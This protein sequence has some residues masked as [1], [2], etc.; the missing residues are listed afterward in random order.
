MAGFKSSEISE[1]IEQIRKMYATYASQYKGNNTFDVE[2][3]NGRY[4][5][6]LQ[7]K[8]DIS[9]FVKAELSVMEDLVKRAEVWY[10]EKMKNQQVNEETFM[11]KVDAM[12]EKFSDAITKY[13]AVSIHDNSVDEIDR[14]YGAFIELNACYRSIRSVLIE[15]KDYSVETMLKDI[16]TKIQG[17]AISNI[18][19]NPPAIYIDYYR[20]LNQKQEASRSEQFVLKEAG[21]FLHGFVY[22]FDQIAP[23]ISRIPIEVSVLIPEDIRQTA[24][25]VYKSL[26]NKNQTEVFLATKSYAGAMINDFRLQHFRQSN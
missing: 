14:L 18:A 7:E 9:T 15:L 3:F 22:K 13:P 19:G 24:P 23:L 21:F 8:I 5:K 4:L 25:R 16:D 11:S 17:F 1:K 20:D 10:A 12:L 2:L 6:A 26:V